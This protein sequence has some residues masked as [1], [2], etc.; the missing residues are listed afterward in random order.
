MNSE[1]D[2]EAVTA[3]NQTFTELDEPS[4]LS[5]SSHFIYFDNFLLISLYNFLTII[6]LE[7]SKPL[8]VADDVQVS[9]LP[10]QGLREE[11]NGRDRFLLNELFVCSRRIS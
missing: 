9:F 2:L 10:S 7:D 1:N 8:D 5:L 3:I 11:K 6:A 4:K